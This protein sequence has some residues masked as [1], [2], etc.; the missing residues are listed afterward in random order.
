MK[1]FKNHK[2]SV[3]KLRAF[4]E[5]QPEYRGEITNVTA[6]T[7]NHNLDS[8]IYKLGDRYILPVMVDYGAHDGGFDALFYA[9][10]NIDNKGD[11]KMTNING[12]KADVIGFA[13]QE[14][15]IREL[16]EYRD[17][18]LNNDGMHHNLHNHPQDV[19]FDLESQILGI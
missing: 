19:E 17:E 6:A 7:I 4:I 10:M 11:I 9:T 3:D 2:F 16:G 1:F 14:R 12:Q 5:Q 13:L 18:L 8:A 15:L